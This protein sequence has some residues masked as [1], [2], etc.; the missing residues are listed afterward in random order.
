MDF[1]KFFKSFSIIEFKPKSFF[2]LFA[3][4]QPGNPDKLLLYPSI[5]AALPDYIMTQF[6]T[7]TIVQPDLHLT[8]EV[9]LCSQGNKHCHMVL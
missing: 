5:T 6:R 2:L 1:Q 9:M 7:V 3:Q 4:V 8:L